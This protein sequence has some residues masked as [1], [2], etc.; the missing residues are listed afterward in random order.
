MI[1]CDNTQAVAAINHGS[2]RVRDGRSISRQLAE[3]AISHQFEIRS[4]HIAG[5]ENVRADRLSR[6]LAAAESQNLRLKP[7][8]FR[9]LVGKGPYRP[10]VDCCCDALGLNKQPGCSVFF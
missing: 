2:T 1:R 6:Q 3:L 7:S 9:K 4:E 10:S 5:V 8:V